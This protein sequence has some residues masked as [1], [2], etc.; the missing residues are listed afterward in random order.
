MN[1][2]SG[3]TRPPASTQFLCPASGKRLF[4]A[5]VLSALVLALGAVQARA[6]TT[7]VFNEVMYHPATNEP[8][9]EWLEL[10][11]QLAVDID[12]SHWSLTGGIQFAFAPNTV[13][14]GGGC[15]VV[16]LSP[17]A[18]SAATGLT[19]ILGPFSGRLANN[20]DTLELR[21]N[22]GRVVD[23][24][25]YDVEGD[26]PVAPDGSGVSL[27]KHDR[28]AAS[29]PAENWTSSE[30]VG[31]T[32]GADN[33]PL[34]NRPPVDQGLVEM[35]SV[36]RYQDSGSDPGTGWAGAGFDD[37]SWGSG[38]AW[39]SRGAVG[40]G[41]TRPIATL[42]NT[43]V[44]DDGS[45]LPAGAS[46]PHYLIT[47]AAQGGINRG[48]IVCANNAAWIG[49]DFDSCWIGVTASGA[50]NVAVGAYHF[51]TRF[52]L[53]NYLPGT[54]R[55][56]LQVAVDNTCASV[57]LNGASAGINY[58][59]FAAYSE[60]F[61]LTTGFVT[62]TNTLE[63]RTT[64]D[65]TSVNPAGF[66][67]LASG[68]GTVVITNTALA[69]A[70]AAQYFRKAF[71]FAGDP[72][73]TRLRLNLIADDGAVVYLNGAEVF[74]VNLPAGPVT[75]A[76]LAL[77]NVVTPTRTGYFEVS[78]ASLVAGTNVLAIELHQAAD[79]GDDALLGAELLATPL[80]P[81]PVTLAFNE[82]ESATNATFWLEL[83]NYGTDPWSLDGAV[84][85]CDGATNAEY[86][87]PTPLT[88]GPGEFLALTNTTL[89]FKPAS[90]DRLVLYRTGK[91]GVHDA[92]VVKNRPRARHPDGTGEWLHPSAPTPG[93]ANAFAF[94]DEL[95]IHEIMYHH[96]PNPSI[97]HLPPSDNDEAWIELVNRSS[98]A[99][100]L[101]G[102]EL[103]GGISYR[104]SPGK[105]IAPGA[106]LIVADDA[107]ALRTRYPGLD[108]VGD[109]GGRLSHR[110]DRIV[111]RDLSGN[112]A[113][114]VR[115][116]DGPPWPEYADGGG[117]TLEL[118]DANADNARPE[119]WAASDESGRS[120]WQ[121]VT[122]RG[123]AGYPGSTQPTTWNDFV[124]GLLAAGECLVDDITV[125]ES[126][127]NN[128]VAFL[129]NGNFESGS[130]GWRLLGNHSHSRVITDPDNPGNHV[131]HLVATGPQEHMHNHLETTLASGHSVVNGRLY[132]ISFRAKWLAGNNLL[133]TRLYFNRVAR[134]TPLDV[135]ALSGTPG[136]PNSRRVSNA[137]PTF[138]SFAHFPVI[139]AAGE[140]V[141]VT[142][143]AQDPQGV[144]SAD[145][146]W[147]ANGGAWSSA[148]MAPRSGGRLAG[149]IPGMPAGT[150]VQFYVRAVDTL[151][152]PATHPAAG[153]DSGALYTVE[154][155]QA[156][157]EAAH[158]VRLILTPAHTELLHAS[159]NVMSNDGLPCTVV[160]DEQ[161]PYYDASLRLKGSERG[162]DV[163]ARVSY[164]VTFPTDD[165]FRGVHPVMLLDRARGSNRGPQEEILI[166]HMLLRAGGIPGIQA[167]ICRV[168]APRAAQTG[169]C[170]LF[171]RFEDEF[172]ETAY[173]NGND[174]TL[175]ELELVYY[176]TTANAAGYK[177]PLPDS[178][179]SV[180]FQD[181]GSDKEFYRYNDIIKNHRDIDD[182]RRL[183]PLAQS[184]SLPAAAFEQVAP[185]LMD[186]DQW[187]RGYA[188]VSLCGIGDMY[189]FGI[190]H[191]WMV[192]LRPSDQRFL[193]FPWDMDFT[194]TRG[195][196]DALVGNSPSSDSRFNK[197][198]NQP[199]NLRRF[200][201]HL[202]DII[203]LS[204]NSA[205]MRPWTEHYATFSPGTSYAADLT[206]IDSRASYAR[207][208]IS[209]A[210]GNTAFAVSG[211][212]ELTVTN[213]L[214]ALTGTA[215]VTVQSLRVNGVEYPVT[216]SS[217]SAWR[218]GVP[219]TAPTNQLVIEAC[220]L[221]GNVLAD[222]TCTNTV[223]CAGPAGDPEGSVV[224]N[225]L[226]YN[227]AAPDTA[228]V[229]L[230]NTSSTTAFDL[231]GW[232]INGLAFTFP[233]GTV[234]TNRQ[235]L[236]VAGNA[237]AFVGTYGITG[238]LPAGTFA[239]N[240][241]NDGET[242]TLLRPGTN[243]AEG[244]VVD[245]VRYESAPPW[246]EEANGG[247]LS[248]QLID[249]LQDNSRAGNWT[250]G[251]GWRFFSFTGRPGTILRIWLDRPGD[252]YMDDLRL[253]LGNE[254]GTGT[255][256]VVNGGFEDPLTNSW[257][258]GGGSSYYL[259]NSHV[260]PLA[261]RAGSNSLH[262]IFTG[263]GGSS[264]YLSQSL[265]G[266]VSGTNYTVS[267]W[268]LPTSSASNLTVY[269]GSAMRPVIHVQPVL[270]T[271]GA[272]NQVARSMPAYPTLWLN[273]VQPENTAGITDLTGAREPWVELYNAGPHSVALDGLFL[274]D[275]YMS[276]AHWPFPPG[277]TLDPG[278]ARIVFVD[279]HPERTTDN[280]WHA[281]FRLAPSA[282]SVALSWTTRDG[283]ELLDYLN[284]TNLPPDR[285]YGD[286][287]DGQPFFRQEF[288]YPTP[289]LVNDNSGPPLEV[290]VNEWMAANT[291]TLLNTNNSNRYDD[292][293]ELHNPG[294]TPASLDG[295]CLTDNLANPLQCPIP[296]GFVIPPHGFLLVWADNQPALSNPSLPEL[297]VNFRLD[298]EGESIGLF[299][300]DGTLIDAVTFGPQDDDITE[301][302]FPDGTGPVCRLASPTPW[303]PN[304]PVQS[305][306][307]VSGIAPA[308]P[309]QLAITFPSTPGRHYRVEYRDQLTEG[310]WL[311]LTED[312]LATDSTMFL[313]VPLG[314]E[315]QRFYRV[316][317]AD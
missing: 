134:T 69:A 281:G 188:L 249:P 29:G 121:T 279:G 297:H 266:I 34:F 260:S 20:G 103:T 91:T 273:E 269:L 131:L 147:S 209:A 212:G 64:N 31:G 250:T 98:N 275:R 185:L 135:P 214:V 6:G 18:L 117:S 90:G 162:R 65:G 61:V 169:P 153:P 112:P 194:F 268:Y 36:W 213:N 233:A 244:I 174:G 8:A 294:D 128:P 182:Y 189:T 220:D 155:G 234:L 5:P 218:L 79:G 308:G 183:L 92:V 73:N 207:S 272:P 142:V 149:T 263:P 111:L 289:G 93:A 49:N 163:P 107:P 205:Y 313:P 240:L 66:R 45:T 310:D 277:K 17:G 271:P 44:A 86:V 87:L 156:N 50:D 226:M 253:V 221:D 274:S 7:I 305:E 201:A 33:F 158:N 161:R 304:I 127:T 291:S 236:L 97:D 52:N 317:Q 72:A 75:P 55:V 257:S 210:G 292:W 265:G 40:V 1:T 85:Y 159:T 160:Y 141:T 223:L 74:R 300:S 198:V 196:T 298:L 104:F 316:V 215:P 252:L 293:F 81:P 139:P 216:W 77:T 195:A 232:R 245:R 164:H 165:L 231:S 190:P 278:Q 280:E 177:L 199:A 229:E 286:F 148:P 125:T 132:E 211:P 224:I 302:R 264:A 246:P 122:Y 14:R 35:E 22:N 227:P 133:N 51:Q 15:L 137:G 21:D 25:V 307:R 80:E 208:Q 184:F 4:L 172:I 46:D 26:W 251:T 129:P 116:F 258:F 276:L 167:D 38:A 13:L 19:G 180:D 168:I 237:P 57:L 193:Y 27:A 170:L 203:D 312:T 138:S 67:V 283:V 219:V 89:G 37:S 59:G 42:Y 186:V 261:A 84:L 222:L 175:W 287:P 241:Q 58:A 173:A 256:L 171:P 108:I 12:I 62:G 48:A 28:D 47:A 94:R 140:A 145:V 270:A 70:T 309:G 284:Y 151:G 267:F 143:T 243:T 126:P 114:E 152:A 178:V 242:L 154:D 301:G 56:T 113:D 88:L 314:P 315:A 130:T 96:R 239:G 16:A 3:R 191:N 109:F 166:R 150:I 255:N 63:F 230:F 43:G 206:Y 120:S 95:V 254:S 200:Y 11:N 30:Q 157:L 119:A 110:S 235:H 2:A 311:P 24:L 41:E 76:T 225:E 146:F 32:P 306:F 238:P 83:V 204:F 105:T 68:T 202:L 290:Y 71:L 54:V 39:F 248:L 60:P 299:A 23:T 259:T 228:F 176:P 181:L 82:I 10:H 288:Y 115:Y 106:Y 102:W 187:L 303:Q 78:P 100:D 99:V 262:L 144:A 179:I 217:I 247:G 136:A 124:L 101:T 197:L 296:P 192:Y 285:S 9:L 53:F 282:G 123:V 118:R 295:A